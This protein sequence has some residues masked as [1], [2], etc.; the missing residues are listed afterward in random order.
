MLNILSWNIQQG[1]GSR[2]HRQVKELVA[3]F[4]D[5]IILSEFRNNDKGII[6]REQLLKAGYRY[7]GVTPAKRDNNAVAIFSR[8]PCDIVL[9]QQS[10][11]H[12]AANIIEARYSAFSLIGVYLPHKKKH[13]LLPYIQKVITDSQMPYIIAGDFN[14]G[15]NGIDQEG[16]S[17]WYEGEMKAFNKQ[18]YIDAFRHFYGEIKEYSWFSHQGNGYRYDHT[19]M[20]EHLVPIANDCHYLHEWRE[21]KLSDH[22]P[23]LLSLMA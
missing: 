14:T 20:S 12:Y 6:I 4:P 17:F 10:D 9:H 3:L 23:M 22:S 8:Y 11:E 16:T 13:R 5:I 15:I 21:S 2:V 18:G 1:G 19:Y 7:Q